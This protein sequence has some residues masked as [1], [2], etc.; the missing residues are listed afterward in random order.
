MFAFT[1]LMCTTVHSQSLDHVCG[2]V[3]LLNF[4]ISP[5]PLDSFVEC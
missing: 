3:Y 1:L 2:T 5:F 4:V